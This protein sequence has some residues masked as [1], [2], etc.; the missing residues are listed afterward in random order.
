MTL[1]DHI[2][3]SVRVEGGIVVGTCARCE[4]PGII[5]NGRFIEAVGVVI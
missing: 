5:E 3:R 4:S 1:C 2:I